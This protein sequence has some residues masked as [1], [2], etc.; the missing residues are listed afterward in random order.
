MKG[1][2]EVYPNLRKTAGRLV[3]QASRRK[4]N[5]VLSQ[6]SILYTYV[7]SEHQMFLSVG[8]HRV[9]LHMKHILKEL[10][11]AAKAGIGNVEE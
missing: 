4:T 3:E 5:K 1:S 11:D 8:S 6:M 9:E 2:N 10:K 7:S